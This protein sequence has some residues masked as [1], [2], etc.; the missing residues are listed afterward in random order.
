MGTF[1]AD[2]CV[3]ERK[4]PK[5][6]DE[7]GFDL[8]AEGYDKSVELNDESDS[9]PFAGYKALLNGIYCDVLSKGYKV[10][11]DI[12]FGTG[13]LSTKLYERGVKIYGQDFSK[14]MVD[15]AAAKMPNA[16]LYCGDFAK[17]LVEELAENKYDA[18][19]ATY[20]LHHLEDGRKINFIK[21]L[22]PLLREKGCLYIGDVAFSTRDEL[23]TC[24]LAQGDDWDDEEYYFVAEEILPQFE[25]MEFRAYSHCAGVFR[26]GTMNNE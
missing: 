22:L 2:R 14:N 5:M 11:L 16:V 25:N 17:G 6:L 15:I 3:K 10:V 20:S 21:S 19:I 26:L 12:G 1:T 7:K 23:E 18:I 8:W 13:V 24:K 4:R 9:Y